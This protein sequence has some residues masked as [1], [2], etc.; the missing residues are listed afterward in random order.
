MKALQCTMR[1]LQNDDVCGGTLG[2]A[3][4]GENALYVGG[5][6]WVC[7]APSSVPNLHS[8]KGSA[9]ILKLEG[10][11]APNLGPVRRYQISSLI[12]T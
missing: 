7:I 4:R 5:M 10:L 3:Y 6:Y 12:Q 11:D 9:W 2:Y 1:W 8:K